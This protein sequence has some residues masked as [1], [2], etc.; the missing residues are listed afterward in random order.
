LWYYDKKRDV[1][2]KEICMLPLNLETV[3]AWRPLGFAFDIDGTLSPIAPTPDEAKLYP[4]VAGLLGQLRAHAHVAIMTG[5][6]IDDGAR[7]V[8]V[9]GLTYIGTHGL[10]WCDGLPSFHPVRIVPEALAYVTPGEK[11]LDLAEQKLSELPGILVERKRVGGA[12]HYRLSPDPKQARERILGLLEEPARQAH[13]LLQEGKMVVEI[14]PPLAINK[15]QALLQFILR[16]DLQGIIFA[17]DDRT[18]LDALVEIARLRQEGRAALAIAVQHHDTL[19]EL[20]AQADIVVPE[21][22]GMVN[23]LREMVHTLQRNSGTA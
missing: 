14:K 15:G 3:L 8:D 9:E 2:Q 12:I 13:M 17:G 19:P 1:L 7:I 11:L 5:R 4:G 21:V 16:F 18:D 6:S 10:E 23:L 20:L 22:D